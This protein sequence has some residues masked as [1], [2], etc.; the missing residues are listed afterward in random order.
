MTS[1]SSACQ[2]LFPIPPCSFPPGCSVLV[3]AWIDFG[4]TAT[5]TPTGNWPIQ[6][7]D[8]E[9]GV[10]EIASAAEVPLCSEVPCELE[11]NLVSSVGLCSGGATGS[12]IVGATGAVGT[13]TYSWNS[14][15]VQTGETASNLPAGTYTVTATDQQGYEAELCSHRAQRDQFSPSPR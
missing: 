8:S 14:N 10:L 9:G 3:P 11:S 12:I 13:V 2:D 4:T 7:V 6:V 5:V 1:Y 15:L